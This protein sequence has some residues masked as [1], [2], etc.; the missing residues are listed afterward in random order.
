VIM[1]Y[2]LKTEAKGSS[3]MFVPVDRTAQRYIP[4]DR[5]FIN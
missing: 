5:N 4:E 3:E 2:T 1:T